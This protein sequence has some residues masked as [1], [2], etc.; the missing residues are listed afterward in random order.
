MRTTHTISL[1]AAIVAAALFSGA[2]C[3]KGSAEKV[4]STSTTTHTNADGSKSK[5]TTDTKQYGST[6]VSKT[7]ETDNTGKGKEKRVEETV[8]GTV[9]AFTAGKK[10]VVL[11]GDGSRHDYDLDDK[12]TSA[13]VDRNVTV[14]TKVQLTLAR[15]DAGNRTIRVVPTAG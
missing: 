13:R 1:F 12:K 4:E 3:A 8:V 5:V 6:L 9:T 15:D 10:I 11:T 2:G 14:G 7:E